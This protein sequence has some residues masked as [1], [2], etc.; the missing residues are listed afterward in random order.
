MDKN[1]DYT[2]VFSKNVRIITFYGSNMDKIISHKNKTKKKLI[3]DG[4][5]KKYGIE[6]NNA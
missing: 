2:F 1:M 6:Q 4:Y 5:S 3:I